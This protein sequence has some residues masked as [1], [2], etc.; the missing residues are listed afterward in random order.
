MTVIIPACA[1]CIHHLVSDTCQA[2]PNGIPAD[3]V[4]GRNRHNS[5]VDGDHGIRYS[6]TDNSDDNSQQ[7]K[8]EP[9]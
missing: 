3:I 8:K 1:S 9:A 2:F 7:P 4:L 6:G 5:P